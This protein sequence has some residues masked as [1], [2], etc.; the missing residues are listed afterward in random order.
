MPFRRKI[1]ISDFSELLRVT[2]IL[3]QVFGY[4][5]QLRKNA[6]EILRKQERIKKQILRIDIF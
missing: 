4:S 5:E 6:E 3:K 1:G 2:R